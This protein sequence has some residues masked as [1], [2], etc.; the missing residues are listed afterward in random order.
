MYNYEKYLKDKIIQS[1]LAYVKG[2]LHEIKGVVYPALIDG[3]NM[4]AGE[5]MEVDDDH[6]FDELDALEGYLGDMHIDNEYDKVIRSIYDDQGNEIDRLP[7]Y[8]Y[9]MR[10]EHQKNRL[11]SRI[12]EGDYVAFMC[13]KGNCRIR[14]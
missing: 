13:K 12:M 10:N 14:L 5:I 7:V 9:N 6:I 4:I 2:S 11:S 8:V 3:E 1:E